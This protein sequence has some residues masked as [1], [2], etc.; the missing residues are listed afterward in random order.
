MGFV[1]LDE[2][3]VND[4]VVATVVTDDEE[5]EEGDV[6]E[7][8]GDDDDD[9]D[10]VAIEIVGLSVSISSSRCCYDNVFFEFS[11]KN[12]SAQ[13]VL[14]LSGKGEGGMVKVCD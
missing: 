4:S 3:E 5:E 6:I 9:D 13:I 2:G 7:T 14:L 11:S 10:A 1:G 12:K 8:V